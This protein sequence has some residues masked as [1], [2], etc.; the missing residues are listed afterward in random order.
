MVSIYSVHVTSEMSECNEAPA[1]GNTV[2]ELVNSLRQ[3]TTKWEAFI[4][5]YATFVEGLKTQ[6][7]SAQEQEM[8]GQTTS[9]EQGAPSDDQDP[10]TGRSLDEGHNVL[11]GKLAELRKRMREPRNKAIA[12]ATKLA[13]QLAA[14]QQIILP[15]AIADTPTILK[16]IP[17]PDVSATQ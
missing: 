14:A 16:V 9:K 13:H 6:Q 5:E 12:T 15:P 2:D 8:S 3:D 4:Y 10:S 11:L 7:E 1:A 17:S